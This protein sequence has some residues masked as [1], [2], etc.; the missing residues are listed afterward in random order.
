MTAL[1]AADALQRDAADALA[2]FAAQFHHPCDAAGRKLV[3]LCGHSLGLQPRSAADY[4]GQELTDW[5]HLAVLGH[6]AAK[7]PWIPYHDAIEGQIEFGLAALT[8][9][10]P[11]EVVAM[12]SLTVNLHLMMVSFFRPSGARNCILIEKSAFPSDRYAIVSQLQFHGLR[13]EEHLIEIEPRAGEHCLRTE[14]LLERIYGEGSRLALVVLPGVQYLT[15]QSLDLEPAIAA[16][17]R[18]TP[19]AVDYIARPIRLLALGAHHHKIL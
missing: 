1:G 8:G 14:D 9:A 2:G 5:Q 10:L 16:A 19:A 13:A 11:S 4:V 17:R 15:G 7:R 12:N 6:D 18:L 3:Y